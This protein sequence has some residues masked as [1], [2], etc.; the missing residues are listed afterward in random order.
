MRIEFGCRCGE[1]R[2]TVDDSFPQNANRVV[3]YCDDCQAFAHQLGRADLLDK[4][5]GTDIV[6]VP[7]ASVSLHCG[8]GD[9]AALRL[10]P[11]GLYRWHT[12]CCNTPV[13]NTVSP[14]IPFI[15]MVAQVF[16]TSP[17]GADQAFG[18][19]TGGIMARFAVGR[20]PGAARRISPLLLLR[21]LSK[22]IL[23]R[24][25]GR[26]RPHPF[27][28]GE[29]NRPGYPVHVLAREQ[30]EALRPLCG[31]RPSPAELSRPS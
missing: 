9:I 23:W 26:N 31:P 5:G 29:G 3:C 14:S 20:P 10:T 12:T 28:S 22:V 17:G 25:T 30:R 7:P 11:T 21:A 1:V 2:G 4:H 27:F 13:G 15:G 8:Q 16:E 19:P 24:L 18:P 6:Q